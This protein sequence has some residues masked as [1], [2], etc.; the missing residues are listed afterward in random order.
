MISKWVIRLGLGDIMM[1]ITM[2]MDIVHFFISIIDNKMIQPSCLLFQLASDVCIYSTDRDG[3]VM[4]LSGYNTI[5][6]NYIRF[7]S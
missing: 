3:E 6:H 5:Q 7:T 1:R 2:E 4:Y